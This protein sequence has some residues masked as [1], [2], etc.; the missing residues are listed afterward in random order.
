[1]VEKGSA[2]IVANPATLP[3]IA[4]NQ[5]EKVMRKETP[6]EKEQEAELGGAQNEGQSYI[7]L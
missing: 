7:L 2:L 4:P 5:K 6:K 3:Q 1:M